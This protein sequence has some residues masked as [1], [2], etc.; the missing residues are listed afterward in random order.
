MG[1]MSVL[2]V[3]LIA[4]F[5]RQLSVTFREPIATVANDPISAGRTFFV[6]A[7]SEVSSVT[8]RSRESLKDAVSARDERKR[9]EAR[10][11]LVERLKV[12]MTLREA[13]ASG[14]D[15]DTAIESTPAS[16]DDAPSESAWAFESQPEEPIER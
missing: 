11:A 7:R 10:E 14:T 2:S 12:R 3:L 16:S 5:V 8:E 1:V 4:L 9:T 6:R 15:G 13:N